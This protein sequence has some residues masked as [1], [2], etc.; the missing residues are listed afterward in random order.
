[1]TP[2]APVLAALRRTGPTT[3]YEIAAKSATPRR[4]VKRALRTLHADG[5][6]TRE[7]GGA[8]VAAVWGIN[9]AM[10]GDM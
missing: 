2:Y 5:I 10:E 4:A 3:E 7:G 6:V 8:G 1:M 9:E